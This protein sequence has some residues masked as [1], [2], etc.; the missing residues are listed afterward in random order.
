MPKNVI[1]DPEEEFW[2]KSRLDKAGAEILD[3][4][5]LFQKIGFKKPP[6]MEEKISRMLAQERAVMREEMQDFDPEE[7]L[8]FDI[9]DEP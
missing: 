1:S 7:E 2:V 3:P 4:R 6:T 8:N 5:P 9:D